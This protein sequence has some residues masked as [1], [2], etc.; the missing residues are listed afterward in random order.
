MPRLVSFLALIVLIAA[1]NASRTADK[2][3]SAK[4]TTLTVRL[5][6]IDGLVSDAIFLAKAAGKAE[7]ARQIDG[8]LQAL[9]TD[10]GLKGIDTKRPLGA[11]SILSA[12]VIGSVNVVLVPIA[13]EKAFLDFLEVLN[14]K[15]KMDKSG[16]YTVSPAQIPVSIHFR[17]ANKYAYITA[18]EKNAIADKAELLDPARVL[19]DDPSLL[20]A[21]VNFQQIPDELK[22]F[23][24]GQ[25]DV[26]LGEAQDKKP[27]Q[28]TE[29]Q[30]AARLQ[31]IKELSHNIESVVKEGGKLEMRLLLDQQARTLST[32]WSLGAKAKSKLSANL[33]ELGERK[34][35]FAGLKTSDT[36]A[37]T[38]L[39]LALP[40]ELRKV[41]EPV[42]D[43]T[44]AT[45]LEKEKD[46]AKRAAADKLLAALKPTLKAGE[47]DAGF[48]IIGPSNDKL[49]TFIGA[50]KL[51]KAE[52]LDQAF[53]DLIKLVPD[54]EREL[55]KF[56]VEKVAGVSI[57]Q[58]DAQKT[59]KDDARATLGDNPLYVA[60]RSDAVWL[61]GGPDGLKVLKAALKTKSAAA[62]IFQ[63]EIS[64]SRLAQL[65]GNRDAER[66]K[67]IVQAAQ[68]L[69]TKDGEDRV[70]AVVQGGK[71]LKATFNVKTAALQFL[72][73]VD[74]INK[75]GK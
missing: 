50:L 16:V 59:F 68:E 2:D 32:E 18:P 10:E 64:L 22:Q 48:S 47:L 36:A 71:E 51:T 54:R 73:K 45:S 1:P 25:V 60:I 28:E 63:L 8:V 15:V 12:D 37:F 6:S 30:K 38:L 72:A 13:N 4:A 34:S 62:P 29:A 75:K 20:L 61:T 33:V 26:K 49:Y 55:I 58:L 40:A 31:F 46:E 67:Q 24:L 44:I 5:R 9:I 53:R 35:L 3:A 56:D 41:L 42:I 39:H 19:A 66:T 11:Y 69:L 17:F 70:I 14:L 43:E 27:A 65:M 7:E 52:G 57:H 23:F 74:E 21:S